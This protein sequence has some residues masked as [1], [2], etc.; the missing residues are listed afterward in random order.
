MAGQGAK[1]PAPPKSR[2]LPPDLPEQIPTSAFTISELMSKD[3]GVNPAFFVYG[4]LSFRRSEMRGG[5]RPQVV[6]S[7]N[8]TFTLFTCPTT[9]LILQ[10]KEKEGIP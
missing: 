7:E 2:P 3:N 5:S 1:R 10:S 4:V 8:T 9:S 6:Y